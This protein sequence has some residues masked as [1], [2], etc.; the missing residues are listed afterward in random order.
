[1]MAQLPDAVITTE[2][3]FNLQSNDATSAGKMRPIE[4]MFNIKGPMGVGLK[5]K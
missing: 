1:M 5:M 2:T 4:E 3:G